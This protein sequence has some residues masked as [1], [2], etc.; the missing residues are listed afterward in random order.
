[1]GGAS[2]PCSRHSAPVLPRGS[3]Q[4]LG[5]GSSLVL[6]GP[7]CTQLGSLCSAPLRWDQ[8][9]FM[10]GSH[11]ARTPLELLVADSCV[12]FQD[13]CMVST[14]PC[15]KRSGR[16]ELSEMG[17]PLAPRETGGFFFDPYST[18]PGVQMKAVCWDLLWEMLSAPHSG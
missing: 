13:T 6:M 4:G 10:G 7:K 8:A 18:Y 12:L 1:M 15:A 5:G 14:K 16:A 3:Q 9:L 11:G 2:L 17:G